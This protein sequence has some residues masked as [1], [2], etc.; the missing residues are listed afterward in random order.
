M[1]NFLADKTR[2]I[3]PRLSTRLIA[4]ESSFIIHHEKPELKSKES[5]N[6]TST[7]KK[8]RLVGG[9]VDLALWPRCQIVWCLCPLAISEHFRHPCDNCTAALRVK[10]ISHESVEPFLLCFLLRSLFLFIFSRFQN[11]NQP[12][13]G[14]HLPQFTTSS[15]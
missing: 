3:Q 14:V 2:P 5:S 10:S 9:G 6:S 12:T 13:N 7:S 1:A 4:R 11:W 15:R 8:W